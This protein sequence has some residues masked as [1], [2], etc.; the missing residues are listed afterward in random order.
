[1][2]KFIFKDYKREYNKRVYKDMKIQLNREKDKDVIDFLFSLPNKK[3]FIVDL[4]RKY[5]EENK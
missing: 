2:G 4:V 3:Q 1:M 5:M